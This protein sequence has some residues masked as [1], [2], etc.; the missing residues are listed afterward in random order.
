MAPEEIPIPERAVWLFLS[1]DG[2]GDASSCC[3]RGGTQPLDLLRPVTLV[4]V[5]FVNV[6]A[7]LWLPTGCFVFLSR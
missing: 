5:C 7:L 4:L 2:L 1:P 3:A 6:E